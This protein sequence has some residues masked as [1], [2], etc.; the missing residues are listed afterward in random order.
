MSV[1]RWRPVLAGALVQFALMI[2]FVGVTGEFGRSLFPI[3]FVGG[4][5]AGVLTPRPVDGWVDGPMAA[6]SGV[7]IFTVA[8]LV[9]GVAAGYPHGQVVGSY[10]FGGYAALAIGV[11]I[12][13][14]TAA[15][16][17]GLVGGFV[18]GKLRSSVR[19]RVET[20]T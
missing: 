4:F 8:V 15:L 18:G 13:H 1:I 5:A 12:L 3:G 10:V 14:S 17:T 11:V 20:T 6:I 9:M 2:A 16:F 19:G 7:L